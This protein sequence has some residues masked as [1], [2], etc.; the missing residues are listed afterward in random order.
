M[1][2]HKLTHAEEVKGGH[3]SHMHHK[4]QHDHHMKEAKKHMAHMHKM[5]KH[6]HKHKAKHHEK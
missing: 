1:T 5:A 4:K 6:A 3:D 2:R